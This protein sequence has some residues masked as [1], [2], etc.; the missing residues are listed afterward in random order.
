[1]SC[2]SR[3][4][5]GVSLG[6]FAM[7]AGQAQ[8]QEAAKTTPLA[9]VFRNRQSAYGLAPGS[10]TPRYFFRKD[11]DGWKVNLTSYHLAAS[12]LLEHLAEEPTAAMHDWSL[13][14]SRIARY[15]LD[16]LERTEP[17]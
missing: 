11:P 6:V 9:A 10:D 5:S 16:V 3:L 4:A 1:M 13:Q 14:R 8:A 7:M 12:K 15:A 17:L 2:I